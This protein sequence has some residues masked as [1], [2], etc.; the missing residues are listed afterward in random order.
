M[1]LASIFQRELDMLHEVKESCLSGL[2]RTLASSVDEITVIRGFASM[3][4]GWNKTTK[5]G[6]RNRALQYV[7]V[8][9]KSLERAMDT[10][11]DEYAK[12]EADI[13]TLILS[14][15]A[16]ATL[17]ARITVDTEDRQV[18]NKLVTRIRRHKISVKSLKVFDEMFES[19]EKR[20]EAF[21]DKTQEEI[22][23]IHIAHQKRALIKF[24]A[25]PRLRILTSS[26]SI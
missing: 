25:R 5:R 4:A 13:K 24:K 21:V 3:R 10:F 1:T 16:L 23:R 15:V 2:D 22:D 26:S 12:V 14:D 18:L 11:D 8:M 20:V 7:S 19:H 17:Q 9:R 6:L